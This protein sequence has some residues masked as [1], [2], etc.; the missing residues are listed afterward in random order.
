MFYSCLATH[1]NGTTYC[2]WNYNGLGIAYQLLAGPS[3]IAVFTIVG[4]FMG[5][6]ADKYNRVRMLWICTLVFACAIILQGSVERYWQLIILRMI[7]AA[8]YVETHFLL[9]VLVKI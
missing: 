1:L 8:G 3:F 2:E 7:M 4:V 9:A 6:A 5:I